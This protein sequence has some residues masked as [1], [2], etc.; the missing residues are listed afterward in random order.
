MIKTV[1][2]QA[3]INIIDNKPVEM[4]VTYMTKYQPKKIPKTILDIKQ[5][6]EKNETTL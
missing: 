4:S 5:K 2:N 3:M 6:S 1:V